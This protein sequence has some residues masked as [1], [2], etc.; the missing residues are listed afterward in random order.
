LISATH[1]AVIA[2]ENLETLDLSLCAVTDAIVHGIAARCAQLLRLYIDG[3]PV[4]DGAFLALVSQRRDTLEYI[5]IIGTN[6]T[7]EAVAEARALSPRLSIIG[8]KGS[9]EDLPWI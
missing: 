7:E 1:W 6:V 2:G 4:S 3:C 9:V 8:P 5:S